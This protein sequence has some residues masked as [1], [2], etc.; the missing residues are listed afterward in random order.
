MVLWYN[1]WVEHP[2]ACFVF[3]MICENGISFL[4]KLQILMD[5]LVQ[6]WMFLTRGDCRQMRVFD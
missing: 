2:K 3:S 6:K 1:V 4:S 5:A